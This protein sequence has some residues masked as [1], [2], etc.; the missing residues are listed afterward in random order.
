[1]HTEHGVAED[2]TVQSAPTASQPRPTRTTNPVPAPRRRTA[3]TAILRRGAG[4]GLVVRVGR[5][6]EAVGA[7]W[8]VTSSATPCSVCTC[9]VGPARVARCWVG[10]AGA[11]RCWAGCGFESPV[12]RRSA[13]CPEAWLCSSRAGPAGRGS[14]DWYASGGA[15]APS[16]SSVCHPR[17]VATGRV[18]ATASE[19]GGAANDPSGAA[20]EP[21][22]MVAATG[23]CIG[24]ARV[25]IGLTVRGCGESRRSAAASG[26]S[27]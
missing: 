12:H 27:G 7:D 22:R 5:G 8:T 3:E 4:T 21:S 11:A 2:V 26:L 16:R 19:T 23:S 25:R 15:A 1:V 20:S 18:D 9:S 10:S 24:T 6:W 13:R 17:G 14:T